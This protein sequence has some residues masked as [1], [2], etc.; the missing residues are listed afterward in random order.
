MHSLYMTPMVAD[1]PERLRDLRLAQ[2]RERKN[3]ALSQEK[4]ALLVGTTQAT[5]SRWESGKSRPE[6]P[7]WTRLGELAKRHWADLL[8]DM[9]P[10]Q[11]HLVQD[12]AASENA[13]L[14]LA[15]PVA[16]GLRDSDR[17]LVQVGALRELIHQAMK[18]EGLPDRE[19]A[20]YANGVIGSLEE[21]QAA[22][23]V[24]LIE[25]PSHPAI[26]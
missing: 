1:V 4:F 7:Q 12:E 23:T 18:T 10:D 24:L 16:F 14:T 8:F 13:S 6:R 2:P 21:H 19:A 26:E 11:A 25:A 15:P 20:A 9:T 22:T 3:R 5:V 17:L